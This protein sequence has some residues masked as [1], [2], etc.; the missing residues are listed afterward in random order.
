MIATHMGNLATRRLIEAAA[1]LEPADR[2]LLNLWIH[3]GLD[4]ERLAGLTGMSV[5][6]VQARRERILA[7]LSELLGEPPEDVLTALRAMEPGVGAADQAA[8]E[9]GG[10]GRPDVTATAGGLDRPATVS[11]AGLP[12]APAARTESSGDQLEPSDDPQLEPSDNPHVE[13]EALVEKPE[14]EPEGGPPPPPPASATPGAPVASDAPAAPAA[15]ARASRRRGRLWAAL[16]A[17]IAIVVAVVLVVLLAGGSSHNASDPIPAGSATDGGSATAPPAPGT[18]PATT[19]ADDPTSSSTT[20]TG[21]G[22]ASTPASRTPSGRHNLAVLPGGPAHLSGVVRLVGNVGDLK[23][24]LTVKG[25]PLVHH[26]YYAA[27]LFNSVLDSRRLGR[28]TRG[29]PNTYQLPRGARHFH[30]IDVSFQPKGTVNHSGESRLRAVNPV[31]GPKRIIHKARARR[32]R[33]LTRTGATRHHTTKTRHHATKQTARRSARH[34]HAT[35]HGH[36]RR[37]RRGHAAHR[38][39]GSRSSKARTS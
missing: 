6:A 35:R 25:L 31:D 29:R 27:W 19:T 14:A 36:H 20:A 15:A 1:A 8:V 22:T 23:L 38:R 18:T 4:D 13:P 7:E 32:P 26:G 21:S 12:E 2:A 9:A 17:G 11:T 37:T 34:R 39:R 5:V 33:H 28:V 30:F 3:R 10:G 24:K 16:T